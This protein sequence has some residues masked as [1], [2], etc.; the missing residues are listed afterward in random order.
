MSDDLKKLAEAYPRVAAI[1]AEVDLG[2]TLLTLTP[3]IHELLDIAAQLHASN[4]AKDERIGKLRAG[5]SCSLG[6]ELTGR[7]QRT[8][9]A[10]CGPCKTLADDDAAQRR[11]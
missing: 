11:G 5:L 7:C 8:H 3:E 4:R 6:Y 10:M 9:G 1:Q 2:E